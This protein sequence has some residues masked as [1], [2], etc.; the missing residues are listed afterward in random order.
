MDTDY[1]LW[2]GL[3]V[4]IAWG[5]WLIHRQF[6]E[7]RREHRQIIKTIDFLEKEVGRLREIVNS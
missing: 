6:E 4:A 5:G 1:P 2:L 7:S 3:L